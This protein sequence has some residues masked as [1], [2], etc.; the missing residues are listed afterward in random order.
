MGARIWGEGVNWGH[1]R[2]VVQLEIVNPFPRVKGDGVSRTSNPMKGI[3]KKTGPEHA[4]RSLKNKRGWCRTVLKEQPSKGSAKGVV[5]ALFPRPEPIGMG[6]AC[7]QRGIGQGTSTQQ[8]R[9]TKEDRSRGSI[10][11]IPGKVKTVG[12]V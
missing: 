10:A 12:G 5:E 1:W 7:F 6:W 4:L 9:K 2:M 8:E 11:R 3:Q